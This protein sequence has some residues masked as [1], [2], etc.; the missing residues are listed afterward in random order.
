MGKKCKKLFTLFPPGEGETVCL[1]DGNMF[2]ILVAITAFRGIGVLNQRFT[3]REPDAFSISA[4]AIR[5]FRKDEPVDVEGFHHFHQPIELH[6]LHKIGVRAQFV[7][8][9]HIGVLLRGR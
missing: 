2:S 3:E 4:V 5:L 8:T 7:G 1:P 6:G 9:V